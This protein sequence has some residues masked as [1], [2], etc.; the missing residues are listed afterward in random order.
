MIPWT[1][2]AWSSHSRWRSVGP[3]S[4]GSLPRRPRNKAPRRPRRFSSEQAGVAKFAAFGDFGNGNLPQYQT[5]A[6][7]TETYDG[8][9]IRARDHRRR[10]PATGPR[11]PQDFRDKFEIPYK[12][13]LDA[14]VKFYAR[15]GITTRATSAL[16]AVQHGRQAVLLVQ[17]AEPG[18]P[19]FHV[20]ELGH[21]SRPGEV[22]R[23]RARTAT[24]EWKI[25]C[26]HDPLYS[27]GATHGSD[28][29]LRETLEP[30]FIKYGVSV[31][32]SGHDHVYE[33]TKPQ[34]GIT[35]FVVG[36]GGELRRG[37]LR[38]LR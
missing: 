21:G 13:L 2:A 9:P 3:R 18:R 19:V 14:G 31:V 24:E 25:V 28:L 27:S 26:F 20:R 11:P 12:P 5:A 33:R 36:S 22:A 6:Q 16:Q 32:L 38:E 4:A 23:Q 17:G 1:R 10:Q 7:L 30:L 35:Y 37:D 15:S 29:T 8:F 34:H